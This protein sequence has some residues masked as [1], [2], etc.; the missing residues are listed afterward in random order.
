M[1]VFDILYIDLNEWI[2]CFSNKRK[3][4]FRLNR[5]KH[6]TQMIIRGIY[7]LIIREIKQKLNTRI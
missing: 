5:I 7:A 6:D 2:S 3:K 4:H 1:L